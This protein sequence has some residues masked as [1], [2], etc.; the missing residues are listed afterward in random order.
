MVCK[1]IIG[2][3]IPPR[4]SNSLAQ[5]WC[6]VSTFR[7]NTYSPLVCVANKGLVRH[8][9]PLNATLMKNPGWGLLEASGLAG[10]EGTQW[11]L[12][13][14][15]KLFQQRLTSAEPRP[16]PPLHVPRQ[17]PLLR[18]QLLQP[19]ARLIL[20]VRRL[21]E[22]RVVEKRLRSRRNLRDFRKELVRAFKLSRSRVRIGQQSR[23]SVIVEFPVCGD[24]ALQVRNRP[25]QIVQSERTLRA[26][27]KCVGR[28]AS[29]VDGMSERIAPLREFPLI[30]VQFAQL[31]VIRRRRIIYDVRFDFLNARSPPKS[32]KH[33]T[34]QSQIGQHFR[35]DVNS[36][37]RRSEKKDDVK[38]IVLRPPPDK[39]HD[40]Q[41]LHEKAPGIKEMT[42]TKHG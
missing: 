2:G 39:V 34:K 17:R 24:D 42:E 5:L 14:A 35:E 11:R 3:S 12:L 8:L 15:G 31:F 10:K 29:C 30:F 19:L 25:R 7:I 23:S 33:A 9:S 37:A 26:R 32:L 36:G 40:R 16:L 21:Q 20:P 41:A 28:S 27:I 13:R 38:P 22:T 6:S 4:A 1:T 18:L